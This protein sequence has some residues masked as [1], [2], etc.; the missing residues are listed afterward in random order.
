M[1]RRSLLVLLLALTACP[2]IKPPAASTLSSFQVAARGIYVGTGASRTPLGVVGSCATKYGGQASVPDTEKGTK[3]CPYAIARGE[4]EI[5][6]TA[7]AL[8][9]EGKPAT[10]F[11]GP[12]SFRVVPG[13]LAGGYANRFAMA[14]AGVVTATIRAQ[15]QYGSTRIWAEDAPPAPIY[16]DGGVVP[17]LPEEPAHRTYATGLSPQIYFEEPTLAKVQIPDGF[18]NR[19]SPLVGEFL[20][21][22][23][24]P[25][26]GEQLLQSCANDPQRD[27]QPALMVIT[28]TD[29][30]GFY[31]TDISACRQLELTD[32]GG[33]DAPRTAEPKDPCMLP[34]TDGG[35]V[36][37]DQW[38]GGGSPTG[39]ARCKISNEEC[40]TTGTCRSYLPGTY[41]HMFIYNYSFPDGLDQGDLLWTLSGSVQEFTS[42]TQMTFPSWS[43]A[44]KVRKLPP[45]QWNKWLQYAPPAEINNRT[46]GSENVLP[47]FLT[48]QL[49]GHNRRNLKMESLE[50]GLVKVKN[51]RF[52]TDFTNCDFNADFRVPFFCDTKDGATWIWGSC[53]FA[54]APPEPPADTIERVCNSDCVIGTG[55]WAGKICSERSTY[56]GFGQ[57]VVEMNPPGDATWG[58]DESVPMRVQHFEA[59]ATA[60]RPG[61]G[62]AAGVELNLGCDAET[63]VAFGNA[64]VVASA[65]DLLLPAR[66]PLKHVL[67]GEETTVSVIGTAKCWVAQNFHNR[68]NLVT[69]DALPELQPDCRLDDPDGAKAKQCQYTRGA[70]FDVTAHLR[71]LQPGRPR[72]ALLPRDADDVCCHPGS[73]LE[74]PR[75]VKPCP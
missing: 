20:T 15:H 33:L 70:T 28:G 46:C 57:F 63:H 2:K 16:S 37:I 7:T 38:D 54:P 44:E 17:G 62:Y 35:S 11:A 25:E 12:V 67:T 31:V 74:C 69:K 66:T 41:G 22:G 21:I 34:L 47:A 68:I 52:P 73:G 64:S 36:V 5:D 29:P 39:P 30:S 26:S 23:K 51:V 9:L 32:A 75:P 27:G 59:T 3:A 49:C 72:W 10:T 48:D 65:T 61:T 56:V 50:S 18:D 8:D 43:I 24:N 42:T 55:A 13:D 4:I 40:T 60:A 45:E 19:S 14:A 1:M 58:F 71:H 6:L 53:A